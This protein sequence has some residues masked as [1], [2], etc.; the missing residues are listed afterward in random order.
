MM[1]RNE[2]SKY[3][4]R[5]GV[6]IGMVRVR[7]GDNALSTVATVAI[8][9]RSW[10][11][12]TSEFEPIVVDIEDLAE[13]IETVLVDSG[14][15]TEYRKARLHSHTANGKQGPT[16]TLN[17]TKGRAVE[18][19][20]SDRAIE[21]LT[22][23][24]LGMA[25]QL[26]K[27]FRT[28]CEALSHQHERTR[29]AEYAALESRV[30][31]ID[32]TGQIKFMEH[33]MDLGEDQHEEDEMRTQAGQLLNSVV[34]HITGNHNARPSADQVKAWAAANPEWLRDLVRDP[35]IAVAIYESFS[36]GEP[37]N[38]QGEGSV[39]NDTDNSTPEHPN[40]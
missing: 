9:G 31:E 26:Q 40:I 11:A 22:S 27:S 33:V 13:T 16:K 17:A 36:E 35:D 6:K 14:F 15:E 5:L 12:A 10:D 18:V 23:G 20:G 4:G 7:I 2:I 38:E 24:L 21:Q 3:V 25:N 32:A 1:W 37:D 34:S 19:A 30:N 28:V 8:Q 29:E 39:K